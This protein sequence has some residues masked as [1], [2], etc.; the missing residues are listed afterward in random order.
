MPRRMVLLAALAVL[1]GAGQALAQKPTKK[2]SQQERVRGYYQ[3]PL[4]R[5]IERLAP[6]ALVVVPESEPNDAFGQADA[7]NLADQ[8]TG[9]V[10]PAGDVDYWVFNVVAGTVLDIDGHIGTSPQRR[11]WRR[12]GRRRKG[13]EPMSAFRGVALRPYPPGRR[14]SVPRAERR[15]PF[16]FWFR[17][18]R[19]CGTT[20]STR[21]CDF[22]MLRST[23]S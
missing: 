17:R 11:S 1:V 5:T 4:P 16:A 3:G 7:V 15:T 22:K 6:T 23:I 19:P 2:D 8:G 20:W 21:R 9:E 12:P 18:E 13:K 10:N 14:R